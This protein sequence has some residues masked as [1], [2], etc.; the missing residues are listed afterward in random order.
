MRISMTL[1]EG[2]DVAAIQYSGS[3]SPLTEPKRD[4][5]PL[6]CDWWRTPRKVERFNSDRHRGAMNLYLALAQSSLVALPDHSFPSTFDFSDGKRRNPDKGFVKM[7]LNAE[8]PILACRMMQGHLI[9]D[10]TEAGRAMLETA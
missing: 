4:H 6:D 10:L 8:P 9:F 2:K 1:C 3:S 7:C 5:R